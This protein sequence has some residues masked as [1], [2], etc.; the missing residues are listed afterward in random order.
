[1]YFAL[2]EHVDDHWSI[3]RTTLSGKPNKTPVKND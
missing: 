2:A 3:G 1:M